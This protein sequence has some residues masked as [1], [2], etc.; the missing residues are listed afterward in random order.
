MF[1]HLGKD[2][3]VPVKDIVSI[4]DMNAM[5]KSKD[6][7]AFLK[8]AVEEGFIKRISQEKIKSCVITEQAI[9]RTRGKK[10]AVKTIVYYS[11]I[12]STTLQ[13]RANLIDENYDS[14]DR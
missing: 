12:S 2:I 14:N 5:Y 13:K 11:P 9:E 1:L 6:S 7:K 10:K 4:L 3:I 8:T